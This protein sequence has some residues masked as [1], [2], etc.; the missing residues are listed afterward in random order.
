[1]LFRTERLVDIDSRSDAWRAAI[2]IDARY[3]RDR[4]R[5]E[6][7]EELPTVL[8]STWVRRCAEPGAI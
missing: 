5:Q 3:P 8:Y 1:M 6:G 2:L 4:G 7:H